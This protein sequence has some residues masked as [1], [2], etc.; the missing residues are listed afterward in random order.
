MTGPKW[1]A[2]DLETVRGAIYCAKVSLPAAGKAWDAHVDAN[3]AAFVI[4]DLEGCAKMREDGAAA[5]AERIAGMRADIEALAAKYGA[6]NMRTRGEA[7]RLTRHEKWAAKD[8]AK[9]R[10]FRRLIAKIQ[11]HGLPPV[12]KV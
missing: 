7:D 11:A 1:T 4:A 8:A 9:A 10:R 2:A 12:E 6:G 5:S 3:A